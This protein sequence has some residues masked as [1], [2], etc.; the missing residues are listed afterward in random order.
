[1]GLLKLEAA[2]AGELEVL[3]APRQDAV[4]KLKNLVW[5]ARKAFFG[6][7]PFPV[8]HI[9][10]E[11]KFPEM[12]LFRERY[13]KEWGL[14]LI[15]EKCPPVE[16]TD[17]TLPP[18]ARSAARKTL[19]RSPSTISVLRSVR[20]LGPHLQHRVERAFAPLVETANPPRCRDSY[21]GLS[22]TIAGS[23]FRTWT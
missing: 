23:S 18:N 13:A 14:N 5:L 2:D 6:H 19:P 1:M 11:R 17:P 7:V 4:V 9:D 22:G 8:M 16:A 10:T 15:V 21:S 20:R 12:Y 3:S